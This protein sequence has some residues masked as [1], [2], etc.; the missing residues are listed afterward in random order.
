MN[1]IFRRSAIII[2]FTIIVAT[3]M[4]YILDR[5]NQHHHKQ[6]Q[7]NVMDSFMHQ[8]TS[9][10]Y[11]STGEI[12]DTFA[13]SYVTHFTQNDTTHAQSPHIIAYNKKGPPWYVTADQ[14]TMTNGETQIHLQ[15]HVS[16]HQP[17]GE[18]SHNVTFRT[19]ALNY[20][21]DRQYAETDQAVTVVQPGTH[22][23]AVGMTAN[24]N[25]GDIHLLHQS[26]GEYDRTQAKK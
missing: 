18:K 6:L 12:K 17:P 25:T 20:Y 10:N 15:N 4:L 2:S 3:S 9:T 7:Q 26:R 13:S 22:I 1:D 24:L 14:G 11:G 19:S 16:I 21:P 8:V 23:E 5:S